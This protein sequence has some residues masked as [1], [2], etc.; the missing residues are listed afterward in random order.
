MKEWFTAAELSEL[1]LPNLPTERSA[2]FRFAKREN[3]AFRKRIGR[4]GGREYPLSALPKAALEEYLRREKYKGFAKA[5]VI[6]RSVKPYK[7]KIVD[8]WFKVLERIAEISGF[9]LIR[10]QKTVVYTKL[11]N[12]G[13]VSVLAV[14]ILGS[15]KLLDGLDNEILKHVGDGQ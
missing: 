3:W 12:F 7:N 6:R 5:I 4:G 9:K 2:I 13:D 15:N 10:P 14:K 1:K 11:V 8:F